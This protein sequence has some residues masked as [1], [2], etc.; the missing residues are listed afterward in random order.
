MILPT[1][2]L[3]AIAPQLHNGNFD[4]DLAGWTVHR[5]EERAAEPVVRVENHRLS[6]QPGGPGSAGVS[7]TF[8][9]TPGSLW[10]LSARSNGSTRIETETPSGTFGSSSGQEFLFRVPSLAEVTIHLDSTGGPASFSDLRFPVP[11]PDPGELRVHLRPAGKR[12]IDAKQQGQF[13]E[14]LCRLIPS[15]MAQQVDNDSFEEEPPYR[16]S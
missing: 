3:L 11:E 5:H 12:P 10:R 2:A 4:R 13:I 8:Y 14:M 15:M 9:L 1:V 6:I 7:Q 16:F